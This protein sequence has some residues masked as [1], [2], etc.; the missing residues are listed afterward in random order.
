[1][2]GAWCLVLCRVPGAVPG[3]GCCAGSG[4]LCRVRGPRASAGGGAV[5]SG[6][7]RSSRDTPATVRTRRLLD[8]PDLVAAWTVAGTSAAYPPHHPNGSGSRPARPSPHARIEQTRDGGNSRSRR[9][10]CA[11]PRLPNLGADRRICDL[12]VPSMSRRVRTLSAS[13]RSLSCQAMSSSYRRA[14]I[15]QGRGKVD[16]VRDGTRGRRTTL[17]H[18]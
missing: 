13:I 5:G 2:L 14:T 17:Q 15:P 3:P 9:R 8:P 18:Q 10:D 6:V 7:R 16:A 4:V 11:A 1:V 12:L